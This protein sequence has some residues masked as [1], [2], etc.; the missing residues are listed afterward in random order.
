MDINYNHNIVEKDKNKKWIE[1]KY[2]IKNQGNQEFNLVALFS[3]FKY[4]LIG[5]KH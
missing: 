2:F 4:H 5:T 1:K 3:P